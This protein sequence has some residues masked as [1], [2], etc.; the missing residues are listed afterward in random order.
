MSHKMD[1][2]MEALLAVYALGG[3]TEEEAAEVEAYLAKDFQAEALLQEMM[4]TTAML[5]HLAPAVQP[6]ATLEYELFARVEA[7]AAQYAARI[8]ASAPVTRQTAVSQPG[9]MQRWWQE[10][11]GWLATP[12]ASG[13]S[14]AVAGLVLIWALSLS[15]QLG[16]LSEQS[17]SLHRDV[18]QLQTEKTAVTQQLGEVQQQITMLTAERDGL[19][20]ELIRSQTLNA[21]LQTDLSNAESV[22][23]LFTAQG[24]YQVLLSGTEVQP[25]AEA[26]IILH[27][28]SKVALLFVDGLEPLSTGQVYQVLL[29]RDDGHDTAETFAVSVGGQDAL[30]VH[31]NTPF[32]TFTA[33]G[34]SIEPEGGSPQRTGEIV[35]LGSIKS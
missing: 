13:V 7:D 25:L 16:N 10:L 23:A 1:E 29:I 8:T 9:R 20:A 26:Q 18:Q 33:V 2:Q 14:L 15:Q 27:P 5:A 28:D 34:V 21:S 11:R 3:L 32:K 31:A 17:A 24:A 35:L 4:H 30:I 19:A 12:L 22:L 6:S